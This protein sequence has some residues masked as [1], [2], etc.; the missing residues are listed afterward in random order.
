MDGLPSSANHYAFLNHSP[1]T[2]P[3]NLPPDLDDRPLGRQKRKR[4][5]PDDQAALE[6]AY[7]LDPKPDKA[8]RLE[9]VKRVALGEKEVQIWFQNR[10]QSSRRKSRPLLPHEIVQ[11]QLARQGS[12]S[13]D[14]NMSFMSSQSVSVEDE[15]E[16]VED[17][18]QRQLQVEGE[19]YNTGL[20]ANVPSPATAES[21]PKQSVGNNSPAISLSGSVEHTTEVSLI[22]SA[23]DASP[24]N[25]LPAILQHVEHPVSISAVPRATPGPPQSIFTAALP[26]TIESSKRLKKSRSFV[27]LSMSSDGR[28]S[29]STQNTLSPS[30]PRPRPQVHLVDSSRKQQQSAHIPEG[31]QS[32]PFV[33]HSALQR[34]S[35]GRSRDSRAWEFWCDKDSRT[36]L[37]T[38]AEKDSSGSAADAIGLLRSAS[39]RSVLGTI[40]SKRN[41]LLYGRPSDAKRSKLLD[42]NRPR[43]KRSSTSLRRLQ[44]DKHTLKS[45]KGGPGLKHAKSAVSTSIPANDSDKEN[46]SPEGDRPLAHPSALSRTSGNAGS[47]RRSKS[48]LGRKTLDENADPE[49]DPELA[50]FMRSG[51]QSN[52]MSSEE[53]MDCVQGLLSLSQGNWK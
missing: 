43:L 25:Q 48:N 45:V 29:I 7:K 35:S 18:A 6:A 51:R 33:S 26:S 31:G 10:R 49:A 46:W 50:A 22:A 27:R 11:Y 17:N 40:P 32:S 8:A 42:E 13:Q 30:P 39:G 52:S 44:G 34:S 12:F 41:S 9:L 19:I 21:V 4:T 47:R 38:Q 37:E 14:P 2:L 16:V 23:K 1:N 24:T 36:E 53:D 5:S 28:A 20:A 3:H 15:S